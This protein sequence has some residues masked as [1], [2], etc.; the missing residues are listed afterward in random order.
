MKDHQTIPI[1][2]EAP[3]KPPW[4]T[5]CNGCGVCCAAEPC[6]VGVLVTGSRR[7]ACSALVWRQVDQRYVC[8]MVIEPGRYL[9]LNHPWLNA[10]ASCVTRRLISAGSG[11]DS[12]AE[13]IC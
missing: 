11:C 12:D 8:G 1:H 6:P 2:P 4:G 10:A 9:G 3:D 5:K 7:G 13:L